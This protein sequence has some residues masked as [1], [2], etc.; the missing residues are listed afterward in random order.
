MTLEHYNIYRSYS[1]TENVSEIKI[2]SKLI[3]T[4]DFEI[5]NTIYF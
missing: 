4:I 2:V 3:E 5:N 1:R